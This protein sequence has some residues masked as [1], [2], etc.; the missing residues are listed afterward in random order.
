MSGADVN[1]SALIVFVAVCAGARR[2]FIY[3]ALG[4]GVRQLTAS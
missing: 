4:V 1:I 2:L 3:R